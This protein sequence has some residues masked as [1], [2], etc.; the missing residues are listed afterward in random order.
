MRPISIK[1]EF[2]FTR[3]QHT[4]RVMQDSPP[5][6]P[7]PMPEGRILWNTAVCG[8]CAQRAQ[9]VGPG[10]M[11]RALVVSEHHDRIQA[12]RQEQKTE[13]FQ[14]DMRHRNGIEGT[15]S[16]LARSHGL[17]RSR[18]RGL[19]KTRLRNWFIAAARNLKRWSRRR[20]WELRRAVVETGS[21][22][23]AAFT[24]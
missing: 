9:C 6:E 14:T 20:A 23:A 11:H 3:G 24:T 22:A 4:R 13:A 21:V 5:P 18:Y 2:Y 19:A 10:Q 8:A 7:V 16:E 1:K 12:R 17:R 15:I